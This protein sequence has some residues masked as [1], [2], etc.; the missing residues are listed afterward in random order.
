MNHMST[1]IS[2]QFLS[3]SDNLLQDNLINFSKSVDN[4]VIAHKIC[5]ILVRG[6]VPHKLET[7]VKY[8]LNLIK[9]FETFNNLRHF[10]VYFVIFYYFKGQNLD[11]A[12]SREDVTVYIGT[13]KAETTALAE[14]V[15]T[16]MVPGIDPGGTCINGSETSDPCVVV[17]IFWTDSSKSIIIQI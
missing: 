3:F 2:M 11:V 14:T 8:S 7:G 4:L 10:N 16:V 1:K 9:V 12:S 15:L 6:A 5:S 13:K 17:N